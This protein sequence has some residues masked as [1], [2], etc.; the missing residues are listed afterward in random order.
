MRLQYEMTPMRQKLVLKRCLLTTALFVSI[1]PAIVSA[2][3]ACLIEPSQASE[4]AALAPGVLAQINAD[5]GTRVRRG[6]VLALLTTDVEKANLQAAKQR[7]SSEAE[8][9]AAATNRDLAKLK[10]RKSY[11]LMNLGHGTQLEIDQARLEHEVADH[12]LQHSKDMLMTAR[13]EVGVAQSQLEQRMIRSPIDGVIAE[14]ALNVGERADGKAVFKIINLQKL[15]A[16]VILPAAQFGSIREGQAM[17]V[18]PDMTGG[19]QVLGQITQVDSFLDAASGTFRAR[20][21]IN[22]A[23]RKIPAGVKCKV[24]IDNSAPAPATKSESTKPVNTS[25]ATPKQ[26]PAKRTKTAARTTHR[27]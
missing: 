21:S 4:V 17:K 2:Q 6:Q 25:K 5:R 26:T 23:D 7:A 18:T 27:G 9:D 19:Q 12:R 13:K 11:D 8:I 22:N 10:L 15:K 3:V 14:R 16:E 20:L 24:E 1:A